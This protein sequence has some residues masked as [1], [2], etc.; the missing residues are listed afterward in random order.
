[1]LEPEEIVVPKPE[2]SNDPMLATIDAKI[3]KLEALRVAYLDVLA[4]GGIGPGELDPSLLGGGAGTVATSLR[5]PGSPVD[6][7]VGVFRDKSI[8]E[9]IRIFLAAMRRKQTVR[10]IATGLK[11]GG[12]V[13]NSNNWET[14]V[15]GSLHRMKDAGI[16][17]RF[18]DGWDLA[19]SYPEHIRKSALEPKAKA[20]K[21]AAKSRKPART[22]RAKKAKRTKPVTT[23]TGPTLDSRI[24]RFVKLR[25]GE[26]FTPEQIGAGVGESNPKFIGLA[27]G[28]MTR[29][30]KIERMPDGRFKAIAVEHLRAV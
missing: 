20:S 2:T 9:A 17:L 25:P 1:M 10:D 23:N 29:Y 21:R 22:P 26:E 27:L 14:T 13:S 6:L 15:T 16:V 3:A 30:D 8:P 18:P 5:S 4:S 11:E 19:E 28:R 7:P 12:L 24:A